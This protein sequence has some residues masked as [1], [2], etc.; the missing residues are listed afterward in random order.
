M[1]KYIC[2]ENDVSRGRL[3]FLKEIPFFDTTLINY[4]LLLSKSE[5]T[6]KNVQKKIMTFKNEKLVFIDFDIIEYAYENNKQN[7]IL[8][9][10]TGL[11]RIEKVVC[12]I[13][14]NGTQIA[15]FVEDIKECLHDKTL[16]NQRLSF[17]ENNNNNFQE[18]V[19]D[20]ICEHNNLSDEIFKANNVVIE[21]VIEHIPLNKT[22]NIL[23]YRPSA[24]TRK[25]SFVTNISMTLPRIM[26][27]I[28][29]SK[30]SIDVNFLSLHKDDSLTEI[31]SNYSVSYSLC[32]EF[33]K[34]N[35]VKKVKLS[36][37]NISYI[38]TD[39]LDEKSR[40][41]NFVFDIVYE[42]E[43]INFQSYQMILLYCKT[44]E[45]LEKAK[46]ILK[47][48][49]NGFKNRPKSF[50]IF[51]LINKNDI[52]GL[53]WIDANKQDLNDLNIKI[54][55]PEVLSINESFSHKS[56]NTE[57]I[58][59]LIPCWQEVLD[60]LVAEEYTF[61]NVTQSINKQSINN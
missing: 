9:F 61:T 40:D 37:E 1:F 32:K 23:F 7:D 58:K 52:N 30:Y 3:L 20:A 55:L 38:F 11:F 53:N 47:N 46:N 44:I 19:L 56:Q 41:G 39:F 34:E 42:K 21:K 10:L 25:N 5:F 31:N 51:L 35:L 48:Q 33:T 28:L 13:Y 16:I 57:K 24:L 29:P 17:I 2:F 36:G 14:E 45:E 6:I 50:K 22:V 43:E 49:K 60:G 18:M 12:F 4:L 15:P 54:L 59:E 8:A 27:E 26:R